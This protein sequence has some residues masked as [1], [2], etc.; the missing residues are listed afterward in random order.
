[1]VREGHC[2]STHYS[3]MHEYKKYL[4]SIAII[5]LGQATFIFYLSYCNFSLNSSPFIQ[6]LLLAYKQRDVLK[7]QI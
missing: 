2:E 5:P 1:M 4:L 7:M 6:T 3:C